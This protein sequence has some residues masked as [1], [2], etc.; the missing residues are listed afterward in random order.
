M[1]NLENYIK[2]T[3]EYIKSTDYIYG[4]IGYTIFN[5]NDK[6]I[7]I[8]SD[9]HDKLPAC[10]YEDKEICNHHECIKIKS[11]NI[12]DWLKDK[13][14]QSNIIVLLE[15]IEREDEYTL[16]SLWNLSSHTIALANLYLDNMNTIIPI[17]IRPHLIP[18]SWELSEQ[19]EH[20]TLQFYIKDI[21][22]FFTFK[23]KK[24]NSLFDK[25]NVPIHNSEHLLIHLKL[26][27]DKF[28]KLYKIIEEKQLLNISVKTILLKHKK[29]FLKFESILNDCMEWYICIL[30]FHYMTNYTIIIH[31]GLYHT[32]KL[33]SILSLYYNFNLLKKAGDVSLDSK[34][35]H[36][37]QFIK[38]I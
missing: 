31:A 7:I 24:L 9:M 34:R 30:I 22:D 28:I 36:E 1:T 32:S 5:N 20:I 21:Q 27:Y 17:D 29:I 15:E 38:K 23:H 33:N 12:A 4:T 6:E 35:T 10:I 18:F 14:K 11:I 19:Y 25:Y 3:L 26:I 16:E 13:I 8:F 37:C 2:L